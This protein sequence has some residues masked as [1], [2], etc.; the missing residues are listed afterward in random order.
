MLWYIHVAVHETLY[1]K[2]VNDNDT[3]N[4]STEGDIFDDET[5]EDFVE[6]EYMN[7]FVACNEHAN[8][9]LYQR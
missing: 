1:K 9:P 7:R 6:I 4:N 5:I 3:T 8:R 2:I